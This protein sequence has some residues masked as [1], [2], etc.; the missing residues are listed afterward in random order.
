MFARTWGQEDYLFIYLF[1]VLRRF[2]HCTGHI[3]TGSWKGR[4]NQYI[5]FI[6]KTV[7]KVNAGFFKGFKWS[8]ANWCNT[9]G[10]CY[11]IQPAGMCRAR[12]TCFL[13]YQVRILHSRHKEGLTS[14]PL[15]LNIGNHYCVV[16]CYDSSIVQ[17]EVLEFFKGQTTALVSDS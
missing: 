7:L 10:R 3:T 6:R 14:S 16:C 15:F 2:Q 4:G 12:V 8:L 11:D 9:R 13:E 17:L 5:Q 1:G